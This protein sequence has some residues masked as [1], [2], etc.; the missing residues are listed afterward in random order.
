MGALQMSEDS[1]MSDPR[2]KLL[3]FLAYCRFVKNA[4][5][6]RKEIIEL[7][8]VYLKSSSAQV[9]FLYGIIIRSKPVPSNNYIFG[10][11]ISH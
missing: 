6:R 3:A 2:R 10:G 8:D 7:Q 4:W 5:K 11:I 9:Q 1:K